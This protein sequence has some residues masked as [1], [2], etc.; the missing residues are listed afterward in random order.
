MA[1]R[2]GRLQKEPPCRHRFFHTPEEMIEKVA[3]Y[4]KNPQERMRVAKNGAEKY[5]KLFNEKV[6]GAY[7]ADI[8]FGEPTADKYFW[9]GLDK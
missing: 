6:I 8:L 9:L 2:G 1:V 5:R 7:I 4:H 3:Y